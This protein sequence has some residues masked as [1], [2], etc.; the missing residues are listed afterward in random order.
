[1]KRMVQL[2]TMTTN[3]HPCKGFLKAMILCLF[4]A[5][6][7]F[8]IWLLAMMQ[9]TFDDFLLENHSEERCTNFS[10]RC[11]PVP[12]HISPTLAIRQKMHGLFEV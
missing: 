6:T 2:R 8:F 7:Y 9:K 5:V 10:K 1:M 3:R 12:T 11:L 4:L